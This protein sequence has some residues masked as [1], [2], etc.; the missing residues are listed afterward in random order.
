MNDRVKLI[1]WVISLAV[2]CAATAALWLFSPP[3]LD[4]ELW[5]TAAIVKGVLPPKSFFPGVW[6]YL[7][8]V[9]SPLLGA[10]GGGVL[11]FLVCLTMRTLFVIV[12]RPSAGM[13][14]WRAVYA[15]ALSAV[16]AALVIVSDPVWR[17]CQVLSPALMLLIAVA[18][19]CFLFVSWLW[20]AKDWMLYVLMLLAGAIASECALVFVLL[21]IF[22]LALHRIWHDIVNGTYRPQSGLPPFSELPKW[23]MLLCFAV[24][25]GSCVSLNIK[26]FVLAGGLEAA[27]LGHGDLVLRYGVSLL[28]SLVF[29]ASPVGWVLVALIGALPFFGAMAVLVGQASDE[30]PMPFAF[31]LAA[32]LCG[33]VAAFQVMPI[34]ST[35]FWQWGS[36]MISVRDPV[37]LA[38]SGI[39]SVGAVILALSSFII[40]NYGR[41]SQ[42]EGFT[43]ILL[44]AWAPVTV[45]AVLLFSLTGVWRPG[46]SA[47]QRFVDDAVAETVREAEG[48]EWIFTDGS[49]DVAL[50][51]EAARQGKTL[52][53][54]SMM[55]TSSARD[56][57]LRLRGLKNEMDIASAKQGVP[58]LL[59]VWAG[60]K[61]ESMARAAIQLG[62]EFWKRANKPEPESSGLLA[63]MSWPDAAELERGRAAGDALAKRFL[64]IAVRDDID[65][66]SPALR[67]AFDDV[68]WR[69]SRLARNRN[70]E[71]LAEKLDVN[72]SALK[73]MLQA[74][75]Y[76]R[77][78]TFMQLT[79]REALQ[80]ALKRADFVE[81]RRY[82]FAILKDNEDDA[83]ANFALGMYFLMER[84]FQ[85]AERYL[86]RCLKTRPDE[87]AVLNNLSIICRKQK[88]FDEALKLAK[89]AAE[90]LPASKE[91]K[92]TLS[93]A[94]KRAP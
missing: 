13:T 66:A 54:V 2:G 73:R 11:A 70:R 58:V 36:Q 17:A 67:K 78:R 31:G 46:I 15:P 40:E 53:P 16:A 10:V 42:Y 20:Y 24:G 23:R 50:E 89:R 39:C 28:Q 30:E 51:L 62:F 81:A 59:R 44:L 63:R 9:M 85:E 27:G 19:L 3:G 45:A 32:L 37:L 91:V 26:S 35:W 29:A 88:R 90:L 68:S 6:H 82:V 34:P 84:N 48:V 55:S 14:I 86:R 57:F 12:A 52:R 47:M 49:C 33:V 56:V 25:F 74:V 71:D 65:G 18:F 93:D 8:G 76:E 94:E 22:A 80:F 77:I 7:P 83:D 4:P 43:R 1:D 87:P 5:E 38:L 64:E 92:Q 21:P 72:N 69:L 41:S 79:P 60:E 75:E 61:P